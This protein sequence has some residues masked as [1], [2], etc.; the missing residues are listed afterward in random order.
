MNNNSNPNFDFYS[1]NLAKKEEEPATVQTTPEQTAPAA[2][3]TEEVREDAA[4]EQPQLLSESQADSAAPQEPLSTEPPHDLEP[5]RR[6]M[7][8]SYFRIGLAMAIATIAW[9]FISNGLYAAIS[10]F[11]PE[12]ADNAIVTTLL[13]SLPLYVVCIPMLFLIICNVPR[14]KIEKKKLSF[15]HFMLLFCMGWALMM[16]GSMIGNYLMNILST[17]TG[18]DFYNHLNDT[19]D[20]PVWFSGLLTV[21]LAPIF[22]ELMFRKIMLDRMLPHGE[23]PAILLGGLLFGAFHGNFYQFFYAALLGMLLSFL[24]ARTGKLHHCILLHMAINFFGGVLPTI[25]M[26]WADY[27]TLMVL[28]NDFLANIESV[29][30]IEAIGEHVLAHLPGTLAVFAFVFVQYA[31]AAL[32]VVF[33]IIRRRKFVLKKTEDQL[34]TRMGLRTAFTNPGIIVALSVCAFLFISTLMSAMLVG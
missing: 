28:V 31:L 26:N 5:A 10:L 22:E 11:S 32:G 2:S 18:V 17:V 15:R 7:K 27:D 3:F 4:I 33:F 9:L 34:P 29:E 23:L 12:L 13:G 1:F 24:Y 30:A 14:V 16:A 25:L 20:L 8:S 6:R 21:V 19:M